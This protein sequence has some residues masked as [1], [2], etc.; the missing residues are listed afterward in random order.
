MYRQY[1]R[2]S[3]GVRLKAALI[4]S[5]PIVA[6]LSTTL[7]SLAAQTRVQER[8]DAVYVDAQDAPISEV[9]ASLAAKFS[10]IYAPS[11]ELDRALTGVYSGTLQQVLG[12]I[13]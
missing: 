11:P 7:G 4:W 2:S 5:L 10:L 13:L 8:I 9:L 6:L 3:A 12:R 1:Q